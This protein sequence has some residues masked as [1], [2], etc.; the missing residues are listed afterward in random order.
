MVLSINETVQPGYHNLNVKNKTG[1]KTVFTPPPPPSLPA[2]LECALLTDKC[3]ML[4]NSR[5]VQTFAEL[6]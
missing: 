1:G 2:T 4:Q 3:Q 5:L 6:N